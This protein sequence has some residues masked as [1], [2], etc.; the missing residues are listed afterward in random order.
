[1]VAFEIAGEDAAPSWRALE[2]RAGDVPALQRFFE[3]NPE[4]FHAITGDPPRPDEAQQEFDDLPPAGMTFGG[5]WLLQFVDAR[6]E[7]IGMASLLSDFLAPGVW[8]IG[9]F[10]VATPL[11][12]HGVAARLYRDLEAWMAGQGAQWIRLGAVI[13]NEKAE[14]FWRRQ[15]YV[16][17]RRRAGVV[18]GRRTNELFVFVKPLAGGAVED[19]LAQVARDRPESALP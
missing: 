7:M 15:G 4:Y 11:H 19:Y 2:L 1:M 16:E 13:G 8:H 18:M 12:G 10:V 3:R 17:V 6:G 5:R 14:R 9:L